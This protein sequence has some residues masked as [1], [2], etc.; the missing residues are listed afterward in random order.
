MSNMAFARVV[1]SSVLTLVACTTA[2]QAQT[3]QPARARAVISPAIRLQL[4]TRAA[5]NGV[6]APVAELD[7]AM[8]SESPD[9]PAI[10]A[11]KVSP[12]KTQLIQQLQFNRRP[13][14]ILLAWQEFEQEKAT[15]EAEAKK[16]DAD[17]KAESKE[18]KKDAEKLNED[19]PK[20]DSE[21][22]TK[23][24]AEDD[25]DE[26]PAK[27]KATEEGKAEE[28]KAEQAT[29]AEGEAEATTTES[30]E[31]AEKSGDEATGLAT[32]TAAGG[33]KKKVTK[34][35]AEVAD[36]EKGEGEATAEQPKAEPQEDLAEFAKQLKTLQ[37][38]VT[39]GR[40]PEVDTFLA[41]LD[42]PTAKLVFNQ[43]LASLATTANQ[44]V[45]DA[46]PEV[47]AQLQQL[48]QMQNQQ[49]APMETNILSADDFLAIAK[50]APVKLEKAQVRMLARLVSVYVSSGYMIDDLIDRLKLELEVAEGERTW[51]RLQL[52]E[53]LIAS[54][55]TLKAEPFLPTIDEAMEGEQFEAL[56][57]LSKFYHAR[58]R[59]DHRKNDLEQA[60]KT[61]QAILDVDTVAKDQYAEALNR[62]IELAPQVEESLGQQWLSNA[63]GQNGERGVKILAMIGRQAATSLQ[64][65]ANSASQRLQLLKLQSTAAE[66]LVETSPERAKEW[67]EKMTLLARIWLREAEVSYRFDNSSSRSPALQRDVYGNFFYL[68]SPEMMGQ[69]QR[70]Q[71]QPQAITVDEVLKVQP[72]DKW[73]EVVAEELKPQLHKQ[74]AQL[75]LKVGEDDEA[76]P[77][78]EQL[79]KSHPALAEGL[80]AEFLRVWTDNHDPNANRNRTNSYMYM[81]GFEQRAEG[82]PLTRSKQERNLKELSALIR[83]LNALPLKHVDEQLL[84]RAFT[85]CHSSAEVYRLDAIQEVFGPLGELKPKTLAVL[86]EQMRNNLSGM[87]RAP[88]TQ[89]Q[90]KTNR[91]QQDIAAEVQ[92]GYQVALSVVEGGLAQH[93]E[94]W[95]LTLAKAAL[96]HDANAFRREL[97]PD[98]EFV[99]RLENSFGDFQRA[100]ELYAKTVGDIREDEETTRPF[101]VWYYASMGACDPNRLDQNQPRDPKQI[102]LIRTAIES[103]PGEAAERHMAAFANTLFTRISNVKPALKYRYLETGLA[104]VGDNERAAEARKIFDYYADLVTEIKLE[105]RIDGNDRVG[106]GEPFGVFV[107]IVHTR[108]IERESGGFARYLQNQNNGS[109]YYYNYG[110]PLE[111][112]RDKFEE[113]VVAALGEQFE[114]QSV[115]FQGEDVNSRSLKEDG[116]RYTPYAYVL[117]KAK[118]PE[119]DKLP[120]LQLD[121]DFLDTSGYAVLPIASSPLPIDAKAKP[122]EPRPAAKIEITQT[123]DERQAEEGKLVLE[124]KAT[125]QGL[126]PSLDQLLD[127]SP[128]E[129]E[130]TDVKD[131]GLSVSRFDPESPNNQVISERMWM[132]T[133][134]AKDGLAAPPKTFEFAESKADLHEVVYQRYNDADLLAVGPSIQL[135]ERYQASA[136]TNWWWIA[137]VT[138]VVLLGLGAIIAATS[139]KQQVVTHDEFAVPDRITPFT[140]LGLL[141]R[142][143]SRNGIDQVK[144]GELESARRSI[145]Q[146]YFE[147]E[148]SSTPDLEDIA[149][150]WSRQARG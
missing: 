38:D 148:A 125:A 14:A 9:G 3:A 5:G 63:F 141:D 48:M 97:A 80:V 25:A 34:E 41:S 150:R 69:Q 121:L 31:G 62:A 53:L 107:N 74:I 42:E 82:I 84:V 134:N 49:G 147:N 30:E 137:G 130:V 91:K 83:R 8:V 43:I 60:W 103:L 146:H 29:A 77:Y 64:T 100:A 13:S 20:V 110:R 122:T 120:A 96:L 117:L 47:Q 92:R 123:L 57:Q 54:G 128:S 66:A 119:V 143:E 51:D 37:R 112:Y 127:L 2:V 33:A 17:A 36:K 124:I 44:P 28:G 6:A 108:E 105:T 32:E 115:T 72:S 67:H 142:I 18:A 90:A 55:N 10:D 70:Q 98:A 149:N 101:E 12:E 116:W 81:Y 131:E 106:T 99:S 78:I 94:D 15:K 144:L 118:G 11:A 65:R 56:I 50:L 26:A 45:P 133:M 79:A 23:D 104:I 7:P 129:F 68:N 87:W 140:V 59:K 39:L 27:V 35:G 52:A 135:E 88:A 76:F 85:A 40:W 71:N 102:E 4:S 61:V 75:L 138:A 19:K 136:S 109:V 73:M 21:S 95:S 114:V 86:A 1:T 132:V 16:A 126:V 89:T 111:N 113:Q 24:T 46:S 145:V 139:R 22:S 58:Y 93:P